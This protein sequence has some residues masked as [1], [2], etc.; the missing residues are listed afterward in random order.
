MVRKRIYYG[1][2]AI[3]IFLFLLILFYPFQLPAY[4]YS[5]VLNDRTGQLLNAQVA[6]DG[7]WR[8]PPSDSIPQK[9]KTCVRLFEDEHFYTHPGVNPL[10]VLRASWQNIRARKVVSGAS[11]ITMQV[12]RMARRNKRTLWNKLD[13]ILLAL[14]LDLVYSKEE[15]FNKYMS[16]APFGGN[17][18]GLEAASWRYYGRAAHLLS[19]G[20][21]ATLAVLPNNPGM[22]YPGSSDSLLVSKRNFLLE[23]LHSKNIIDSQTLELAREEPIPDRPLPLPR[24]APQLHST[25][26][27]THPGE[28]LSTTIAPFWQDRVTSLAEAHQSRMNDN[29]VENLAAMVVDLDDGSVL[30]YVGNTSKPEADGWEVDIVQSR[31]SPGSSLKP[32]LYAGAL[33]RGLIMRKSFLSD[34][35]SFFGGF[36]PKNFNE[37]H[38]GVVNAHVALSRSLNIPMV[39][40]LDEYGYEQFH[41]DLKQWGI[42]TMNQ[43]PGHYGLTMILGGGEVTMWDMGQVY[44]S[45][46][47]KLKGTPNHGIHFD[48]FPEDKKEISLGK[49]A[50]WQTFRTMT[51]L[52][53]PDDEKAWRSFSSSQLIAWKTGTS[54]GH[55]D[56]WAI[57]LNGSVLV[58]VWVG[59]ADGEGRANLTGIKAAAPLLHQIMRLSDYDPNWLEEL[60]PFMHKERVCSTS[61]MLASAF[62]PA[63]KE[64]VIAN[65]EN[66]GICTYHKSYVM[67]KTGRFRVNSDCYSISQS[68]LKTYLVLPPFEDYYYRKWQ[69]DYSGIP[70][71]H[72]DCVG[73]EN[74]LLILYPVERNKIFIPRELDGQKG[75]VVFQVTHQQ[76]GSAVFWHIDDQYAGKTTDTHELQVWLEPGEHVLRVIDDSGNERAR[77]F[78]VVGD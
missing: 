2:V 71:L 22:I 37:G 41:H 57:G 44:F 40:L 39:H 10:S 17:V 15:I 46:L 21:A 54:H 53:R 20:E 25:F 7:Q 49:D 59:N 74:P 70:P 73:Q 72:D 69:Y 78:E 47:Q 14:K 13:E 77:R 75:R 43:R 62:C 9:I 5:T 56:A 48:T 32:F 27:E 58:L 66:S 24:K 4:S 6:P 63:E 16:M 55:R 33:D 52:A 18:V 61:G 3:L 65:A 28:R 76:A 45:M 60:R 30:A 29:G 12:A 1:L 31:R 8:F 51:T 50:I 26:A 35:P 67:D 19:W 36:V 42:T 34:V 64:E 68:V 38:L 11:T 23:K